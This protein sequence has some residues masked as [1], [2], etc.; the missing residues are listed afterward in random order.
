M[1]AQERALN[2]I[3]SGLSV[4]QSKVKKKLSVK[5]QTSLVD[6]DE[7]DYDDEDDTSY[8]IIPKKCLMD[9]P[10]GHMSEF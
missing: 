3:N 4:S 7:D 6:S 5:K 10:R 1:S 2:L 8:G 9:D